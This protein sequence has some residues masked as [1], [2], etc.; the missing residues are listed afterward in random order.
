[1]RLWVRDERSKIED[2]RRCFRFFVR[3]LDDCVRPLMVLS[4][5]GLRLREVYVKHKVGDTSFVPQKKNVELV[6]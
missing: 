2:I 1:M 6:V 3:T 4:M 5:R